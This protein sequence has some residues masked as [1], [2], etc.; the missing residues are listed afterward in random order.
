MLVDIGDHKRAET[1]LAER[2]AQLD[3]AGTIARIGSFAYEHATQ[4]LQLSPGCAA[5][6]GLPEGT[7]EVSREDWRALVHPDDLGPLDAVTRRAYANCETEFILE[8]RILRHDEVRWLESRVLILYNEV[9]RAFRR[10]GAQVDITDRKRAELALAERNT[11]LELASE[12]AR[13]GSLA[14]DLSTALV[15]LSPGCAM[16]LGLPEGT[17]ET[18]REMAEVARREDQAASSG[19]TAPARADAVHQR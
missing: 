14:I 3:L 10:I 16:I 2:N 7:V 9:G 15:D 4:T 1:R 6:Y 13:V 17:L 12:T 19:G 5:I 18:S 11:Q 8:F